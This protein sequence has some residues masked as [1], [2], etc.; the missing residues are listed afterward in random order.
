MWFGA[1]CPTPTSSD[2]GEEDAASD[3]GVKLVDSGIAGMDGSLA[4]T[5]TI[6]GAHNVRQGTFASAGAPESGGPAR[7][8]HGRIAPTAGKATG[9]NRIVYG[10]AGA[11]R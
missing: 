4:D 5:G 3:T 7:T 2:A 11:A 1:G 9:P 10:S 6:A 8:V